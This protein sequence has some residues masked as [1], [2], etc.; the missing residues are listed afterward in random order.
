MD[1][2]PSNGAN[3]FFIM[4]RTKAETI[5]KLKP[6]DRNPRSISK[7][8]LA[9]LKISLDRFGDLSGIVFNIRNQ[10]L[11]SSHQRTKTLPA[12]SE[13]I[14]EKH[15]RRPTRTGTVAEGYV[16]IKGERFHYREVKWDEKT[17]AAANVAANN[18]YISGDFTS[19][20]GKLL[21]ELN[22]NMPDLSQDLQ[23][24]RLRAELKEL[25]EQETE[26]DLAPP[27][28]KKAKTKPGDLYLLGP[29][30]LICGDCTDIEIVRKL[31]GKRKAQLGF[32]DPP[33]NVDYR[34]ASGRTYSS[35]A[36]GGDG[37][38]IFNDNK[39]DEDCIEFY[40][41]ALDNLSEIS[42]ENA[43]LYWWF[44]SMNHHLNRQAFLNSTW[45]IS[46]M[47]IWLKES[48]V[49]SRG[50]DY[51]RCYEPC[52]VGWKE[53][54]KHY[55]NRALNTL[56]D[57][58][59]LDHLDFQEQFDVWYEKRDNTN[60]YVHPTQKPV[61]LAERAIKKN[62]RPGDIVVDFFSGSGS[63]LIGCHQMKRTFYGIELDPKYCDV[64]VTRYCNFVKN[65]RITLNGRSV[66]WPR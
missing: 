18:P 20:L 4:A 61:R 34:S 52:L 45:H 55:T 22:I 17:H 60:S 23:L 64:I 14:I 28:P 8:A 58:F 11:V 32:T 63:T 31:V 9:G 39:S 48:F 19:E 53:G 13:I 12:D 16:L 6:W 30:R 46:Q 3:G 38:K 51:H 43:T 25:W 40:T 15:Y 59:S 44:A 26:E 36:F 10:A 41:K 27:L 24:D 65:R 54:K 62:S 33:Y 2:L 1:P 29:H 37:S 49:L 57:I 7:E 21:D 47:I 42:T 5:Q 66:Q 56:R 50:Q 35:G